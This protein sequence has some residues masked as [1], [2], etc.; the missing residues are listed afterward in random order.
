MHVYLGAIDY[1]GIIAYWHPTK[2]GNSGTLREFRWSERSKHGSLH[3]PVNWNLKVDKGMDVTSC[4]NGS[5]VT[6]STVSLSFQPAEYS[7]RGSCD[8]TVTNPDDIQKKERGWKTQEGDKGREN[9][10]ECIPT[11]AVLPSC[12]RH[13]HLSRFGEKSLQIGHPRREQDRCGAYVDNEGGMSRDGI[14]HSP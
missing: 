14:Y 2:E 1:D 3:S 11:L 6:K 4:T 7:I 5:F 8:E 13:Y 10:K 12:P 9:G